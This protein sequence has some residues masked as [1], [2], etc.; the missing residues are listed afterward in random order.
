MQTH[1]ACI[2]EDF[3]AETV[4]IENAP[5]FICDKTQAQYI[6][7]PSTL[8]EEVFNGVKKMSKTAVYKTHMTGKVGKK[9]D[10]RELRLQLE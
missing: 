1:G 6:L 7:K 4:D 9:L 5:L 2:I 8:R 3:F 10:K